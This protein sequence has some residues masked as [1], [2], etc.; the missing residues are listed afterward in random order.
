M[1]KRQPELPN[2]RRPDEIPLHVEIKALDEACDALESA[3]GKRTRA[4]QAVVA[5]KKTVQAL[6]VEHKLDFYEYE[7]K[8]GVLK[9]RFRKESLGGCKVKV[10]KKTD[11]DTDD[12]DE[13]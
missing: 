3:E 9:K 7:T 4:G 10:N 1:A 6:L 2:T 13:E 11:A 8:A 12:G 5:A